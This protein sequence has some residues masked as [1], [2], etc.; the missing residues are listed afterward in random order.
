[1]LAILTFLCCEEFVKNYIYLSLRLII[2]PRMFADKTWKISIRIYGYSTCTWLKRSLLLCIALIS[3]SRMKIREDG[4]FTDEIEKFRI[5]HQK[6]CKLVEGVDQ[7][8]KYYIA[9]TYMTNVPL[10]CLLLY[11]IVYPDDEDIVFR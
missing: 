10:L 6:R 2:S 11:I 3:S 8:F 9:N 4:T 1:M 7:T 5:M